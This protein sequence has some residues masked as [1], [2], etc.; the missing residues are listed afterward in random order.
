MSTID[1]DLRGAF[2][3]ASEHDNP[4][5]A[6]LR[7]PYLFMLPRSTL[8]FRCA[9]TPLRFL[10]GSS[11]PQ[12]CSATRVSRSS[13][14]SSERERRRRLSGRIRRVRRLERRL[15]GGGLALVCLAGVVGVSA[16]ILPGISGS[17]LLIILGQYTR[18]RRPS[19][20]LSTRSSRSLL[21]AE[22]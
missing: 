20:S 8:L 16:M 15:G 1:I 19:V 18:C 2:Y 14:L 22:P 3:D 5:M 10:T 21:A 6:L 4:V 13:P 17:L 7:P 11:P 12:R 9:G